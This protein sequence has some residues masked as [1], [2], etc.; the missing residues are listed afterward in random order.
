M[1][2]DVIRLVKPRLETQMHHKYSDEAVLSMLRDAARED[3]EITL[4]GRNIFRTEEEKPTAD[5]FMMDEE[6]VL[7]IFTKINQHEPI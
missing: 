2:N 5:T 6:I 4:V 1:Q 3:G 7:K